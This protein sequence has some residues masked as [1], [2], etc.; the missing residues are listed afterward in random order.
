MHVCVAGG[1]GGGKGIC[2]SYKFSLRHVNISHIFFGAVATGSQIL[3]LLICCD[4]NILIMK[5]VD[6]KNTLE[7]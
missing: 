5:W 7:G 4:K 6:A 3:G 1:G 2:S